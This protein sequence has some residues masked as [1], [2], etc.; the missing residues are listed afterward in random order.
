MR[1][2]VLASESV[3]RE[4]NKAVP[5]PK[6]LFL[7]YYFPPLN[8][9]GCVRTWNIAKYL[10]RSGW[11]VTV[12]TPDP[13][14]WRKVNDSKQVE[15]D[16][17]R[18]RIRRLSTGHRWR[19]L[20][21]GDLKCW[22]HNLGWLIGGVCRTIARHLGVETLVGWERE[23]ERTCAAL[24]HEDVD[25]ILASGPPFVSFRLAK[26]LSGQLGCP[27]VLD[28]RDA[29][30][31]TPD[32]EVRGTSVP[33][34]EHKIIE[35]SSAVTAVSPSLL[36]GRHSLGSKFHVITNGFDPD[37]LG[38]VQPHR[39][40]HFAIVYAGSF[41][42]PMRVITPVMQAL[43]RLKEKQTNRNPEWRFHYYGVQGDHV[44]Q[45]A[46]RFEVVENVVLHGKV[47]RSEA[48]SAVRG[49]S[50]SVVITS[51]LEEKADRD[52]GIV[53]GKLFE[54]LGL[55]TPVLF[56]GPSGSDA[57]AITE[58]TGLVRRVTAKDV[59]GMTTFFQE[60]MSGKIPGV[61]SPDTY[62]WPNLI[63]GF[64]AVLRKTIRTDPYPG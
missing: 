22:N 21:P 25:V 24:S 48:L 40:G 2:S 46:R 10:S 49:A 33:G 5:R 61:R 3:R 31:V 26:S 60:V 29:W 28:Y 36:N 47:P 35:A 41:Y 64:D 8:S 23:V 44:R 39:F 17:D 32:I 50:V 9:T 59:E 62:A 1:T 19:C 52:G 56:V 37:E 58:T 45:E 15:T 13:S 38:Q 51:V 16:L 4:G 18:E 63:K 11:D 53:T 55:G 27:Y 12:V 54:A 34:E 6:L 7:A 20:S 30:E 14:L 43:K 57:D 42:F